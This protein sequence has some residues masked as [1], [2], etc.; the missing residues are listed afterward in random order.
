MPNG[1]RLEPLRVEASAG[2]TARRGSE[3][4]TAKRP[5]ANDKDAVIDRM[6]EHRRGGVDDF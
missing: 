2:R 3:A 5:Q 6:F 4:K 1:I